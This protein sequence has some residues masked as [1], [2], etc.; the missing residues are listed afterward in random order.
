M[1]N[2]EIFCHM[3]YLKKKDHTALILPLMAHCAALRKQVIDR[4]LYQYFAIRSPGVTSMEF[5]GLNQQ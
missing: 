4:S 1:L 5:M 2:E 3:L